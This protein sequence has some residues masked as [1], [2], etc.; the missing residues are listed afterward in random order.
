MYVEGINKK[1]LHYQKIVRLILTWTYQRKRKLK[2]QL[3]M[4]SCKMRSEDFVEKFDRVLFSDISVFFM[5]FAQ[6][7]FIR[8]FVFGRRLTFLFFD[9]AFFCFWNTVTHDGKDPQLSTI[10]L[11]YFYQLLA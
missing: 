10:T 1:G 9:I 5:I 4:S 7:N 3:R 6:L 2:V 8:F 11:K